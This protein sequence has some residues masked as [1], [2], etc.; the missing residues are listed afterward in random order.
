MFWNFLY[1]LIVQYCRT[2]PNFSLKMVIVWV[3]FNDLPGSFFKDQIFLHLLFYLFFYLCPSKY[4]FYAFYLYNYIYIY[5]Y[6]Y[7]YVSKHVLIYVWLFESRFVW[8][9]VC[10]IV[11]CCVS[12]IFVC[13]VVSVYVIPHKCLRKFHQKQK[14]VPLLLGCYLSVWHCCLGSI[15]AF[16]IVILISYNLW[17]EPLNQLRLII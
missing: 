11:V 2:H 1:I 8:V 5:I 6:I 15:P 10:V 4:C 9:C 14:F 12:C 16:N 13:M 3:Y 17:R 7:I